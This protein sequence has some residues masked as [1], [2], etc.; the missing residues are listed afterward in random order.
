MKIK[1][2]STASF[3][4]KS[5]LP[6]TV[7]VSHSE[8]PEELLLELCDLGKRQKRKKEIRKEKEKDSSLL[9]S[10]K[11][12]S[13]VGLKHQMRQFRHKAQLT[14]KVGS[15]QVRTSVCWLI[16]GSCFCKSYHLLFRPVAE[17]KIQHL[18]LAQKAL[19]LLI[20]NTPCAA[21]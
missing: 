10:L 21:A 1:A 20:S 4:Q 19:L 18:S 12:W 6:T 11:K 9:L 16:F 14:K 5:P 17:D 3:L 13:K 15:T 2:F 8:V 7:K